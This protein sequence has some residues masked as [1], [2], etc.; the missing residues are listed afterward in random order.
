ML[1]KVLL[2]ATSFVL[3]LG[4]ATAQVSPQR[5]AFVPPKIA[6][7]LPFK[8]DETLAYSVKFSKLIFSGTIGEL[9]LT[10]S[11]LPAPESEMIELRA[12]AVSKGVFP[13]LFGVKVRDRY[14]SLVNLTDFGVHASTKLIQEG[15]VRREQKS[16]VNREAA[17]VTYTD[18]DLANPERPPKVKKNPSP[19][20]I[21]DV[22]SVIY[23]VRAQPLKEGDVIAVPLS[24]G[25]EVY[26]IEVVAGKREEIKTGGRVFKAIQLNAKVFDGRYIKR[27]GQ[28]LVWIADDPTRIPLRARVKTSGTTITVDL[29]QLPGK[30]A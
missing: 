17:E 2:S 10:V 27:S 16:V 5:V 23:F 28:M 22:L 7:P 9:T 18:R 3:G 24:D 25:G 1:R 19:T 30:V 11:K 8:L 13:A 20:W 29:K 6:E 26:N 12:E 21:Q 4:L 14:T 15:K